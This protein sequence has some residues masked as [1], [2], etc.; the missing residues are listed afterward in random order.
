MSMTILNNTASMMTLGELNK[1][2]SKVGRQLKR[3]STGQ[4]LNGA[5]DNASDYGI[6]EQMRAKI[7]AL[8]QDVQNVQNGSSMLKVA[9]GGIQSIVEELRDLKEL[10]IDAA[11]D[12]NSDADRATMQKVLKQKQAN[13]DNIAANTSFNSKALLDGT[14]RNPHWK[15]KFEIQ[16]GPLGI[17]QNLVINPD[18]KIRTMTLRKVAKD[19]IRN[20]SSNLITD[21]LANVNV[22]INVTQTVNSVTGLA[23]A[24]TAMNNSVTFADGT[25]SVETKDTALY[26]QRPENITDP[27]T[28]YIVP[29]R[30]FIRATGGA[31][32]AVKIDFSGARD[33]NGNAIFNSNGYADGSSISQLNDQGFSILFSDS[34]HFVNIKFNTGSEETTWNNTVNGWPGDNFESDIE[35]TVGIQDLNRAEGITQKEFT[36]TILDKIYNASERISFAN[37]ERQQWRLLSYDE[38][39][40]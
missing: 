11:N 12:S 5:D 10:A 29:N 14:Y 26:S 31:P 18:M 9:L 20:D 4:K 6:S 39:E 32:M 16:Y 40:L 25:N 28:G 33:A 17:D 27:S 30:N 21:D 38:S 19:E 37:G 13:I 35:Y 1:N 15:E 2:I 36:N 23:S 8:E 34:S 22:K 7:R 24:F 3:V